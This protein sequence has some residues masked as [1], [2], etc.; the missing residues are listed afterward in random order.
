MITEIE[1][2]KCTGCGICV[3]LCNMD[4]LRLNTFQKEIPP[5]QANCPAGVN[6]RSYMYSLKQG[7]LEDAVRLLRDTLPFPAI[8][9]R[10]CYHPCETE[11]A[12]KE[13]DRAVNINAIERFVADYRLQEKV[14]PVPRLHVAKIAIVGSGPAGLSGAY[15][16]TRMGYPVTVFESMAEPGGM[17]RA[18]IPE[19]RLPREVLDSQIDYLKDMGI[20]FITNTRIGKD[21]SLEDLKDRGYKAVFLALG[22]QL[23]KPLE[24]EGTDLE[25]VYGGLDFLREVNL[26]RE[27]K[28]GNKVLVVGGGDVAVD[29]ARAALRLGAKEVTL[30]YRRTREEMPAHTEGIAE[31]EA[32]GVQSLYRVTPTK[33]LGKNGRV[34]GMECIRLE[35]SKP[36]RRR[37]SLVPIKGS[38]LVIEA[39]TIVMAIGQSSDLSHL[40]E[41]LSQ[42]KEG[43]IVADR[44][45]LET[46]MPGVFA[47]GDAVSG[48]SSVVEAIAGGK[49]AAVSIDRFLKR[50][51]LKQGQGMKD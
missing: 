37:K 19:Y 23:S 36:D 50:E 46:S 27:V 8:T 29:A 10:V 40:P 7:N 9:G 20:E 21:L 45:T 42:S 4:I 16:L 44:V 13:V 33:I 2:T 6:I 49:K 11:C 30:V 31:A 3:D 34:V 1:S 15:F 39:D 35:A 5:C 43:T 47:G 51:N 32:E 22:A 26:K 38:E 48:P 14:E 17:L 24:I 28:I 12:R 18:G 25:G 41:D